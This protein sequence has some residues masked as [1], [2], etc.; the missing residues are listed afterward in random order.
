[1][2]YHFQEKRTG[3]RGAPTNVVKG[4]VVV[5]R[6]GRVAGEVD[7]KFVRLTSVEILICIVMVLILL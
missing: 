5:D 2:K 4:S 1:M 3:A 6:R 7:S